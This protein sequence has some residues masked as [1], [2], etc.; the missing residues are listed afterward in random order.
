MQTAILTPEAAL[1]TLLML[2]N[3]Y[4]AFND[5]AMGVE[6]DLATTWETASVIAHTQGGQTLAGHAASADG[7]DLAVDWVVLQD[8]SQI[9]G[10]PKQQ[11]QWQDS[12]DGA[13]ELCALADANGAKPLFF[14]TWG[15]RDG[16]SQNPDRYP[17]FST[18]QEH[19]TEGYLAYVDA[20]ETEAWIAPVGHAWAVIHDDA[21]DPSDPEGLFHRL[22]SGD[23]SH[24]SGLGSELAAN[25]FYASLSGRSPIGLPSEDPD[26]DALQDAAHRAVFDDPFGA[27]PLPF[28]HEWGEVEPVGSEVRPWLRMAGDEVEDVELSDAVLWVEGSLTGTVAGTGDLV[29]VGELTTLGNEAVTLDGAVRLDGNLVVDGEPGEIMRATSITWNGIATA[30]PGFE[31]ELLDDGDEQILML[32]GEAPAPGTP[33][34]GFQDMPQAPALPCGCATG[35]SAAAFSLLG[36]LALR[37]RR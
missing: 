11:S 18:M 34:S 28:A 6:Q 1:I 37:R 22:Y 12:R 17:D 27:I 21:D 31:L 32:T 13:V 20:C 3:S 25:V 29:V 33:D 2:G 16:D 35:G 8:Q 36:L 19:L 9:P 10:F 5:L 7:Y 23:G 4:T 14:L 15:R 26:A 30:G 24:P